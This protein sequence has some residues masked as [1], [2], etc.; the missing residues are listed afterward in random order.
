MHERQGTDA[1]QDIYSLVQLCLKT[2]Q[3]SG[4]ADNS[5]KEL[6]RYLNEF[7]YHCKSQNVHSVKELTPEFLR[8]YADQRCD[9]AGPNLKKVV[10]WSL[11]KFSRHLAM[12]QVMKEDPARHLRHPKFHPRSELPEYLSEAQLRILMEHGANCLPKMDFSILGKKR[13]KKGVSLG[14]QKL[15]SLPDPVAFA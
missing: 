14:K 6:K 15:A 1:S 7:T 4:L 2:G 5:L 11:R 12:L 9:G 13:G 10:V 3:D 8:R